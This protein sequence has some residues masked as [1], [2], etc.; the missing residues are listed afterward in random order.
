MPKLVT[1][2]QPGKLSVTTVATPCP[3]RRRQIQQARWI[4]LVKA[5]W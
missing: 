4:T 1:K 3:N 2:S 5:A